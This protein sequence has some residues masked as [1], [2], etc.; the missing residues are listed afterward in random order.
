MYI[1]LIFITL[2][3]VY[4]STHVFNAQRCEKAQTCITDLTA[5]D[6][7]VELYT[8]TRNTHIFNCCPG[9]TLIADVDDND[10][11][12]LGSHNYHTCLCLVK[13]LVIV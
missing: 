3:S 10:D 7:G 4:L 1:A 8:L 2:L 13:I 5:E 12:D 11:D 9:C 6:C